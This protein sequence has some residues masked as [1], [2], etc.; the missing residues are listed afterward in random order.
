MDFIYSY[1]RV[2]AGFTIAAFSVW[3]LT[4]KKAITTTPTPAKTNSI[5]LIAI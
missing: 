1:L 3:R 4:D 5:G 2:C